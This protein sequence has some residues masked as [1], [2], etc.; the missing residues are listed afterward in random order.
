MKKEYLEIGQLF[1]THGVKGGFKLDSW[2]DSPAVAASLSRVFLAQ[3]DGMYKEL[4]VKSS[5]VASTY[6]LI[7]FVGIDD[8][9]TARLYKGSVVYA[10]REDIPLADG[11]YFIADLIDLPVY[12]ADTGVSYG[13]ITGVDMDRK[14]PLYTVKTEKGDVLFPAI[15]EFV[16]EVDTD[17][18]V[19]VCPISGFF[20]EV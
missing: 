4:K 7:S 11:D 3:R 18:G 2:C 9:D 12:D 1:N 15:P 16:K 13:V 14:T 5:S 10:K 8:L 6:V 19:F 20:D 17:K